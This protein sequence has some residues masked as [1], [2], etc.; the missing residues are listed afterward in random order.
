MLKLK[1][2]LS[3][4]K[5]AYGQEL[6]H[7]T[8]ISNAFKILLHDELKASNEREDYSQPIYKQY[9]SFSR[10]KNWLYI[11]KFR[12]NNVK[13]ECAIVVDANKL[14]SNYRIEPF[15][16][17]NFEKN[18]H[19]FEYEER[20]VIKKP[21]DPDEDD[22][23]AFIPNFNKYVKYVIIKKNIIGRINNIKF[24]NLLHF[25]LHYYDNKK[26][27]IDETYPI[28]IEALQQLYKDEYETDTTPYDDMIAHD[29]DEYN[30]E[31]V[32]DLKS[33]DDLLYY[34]GTVKTKPYIEYLIKIKNITREQIIKEAFNMEFP[35]ITIKFI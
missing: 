25:Y 26:S 29:F 7:Y 4:S 33:D 13:I 19:M 18:S 35:N 11:N 12:L 9:I 14:S 27:E 15:A 5:Y 30:Y 16:A 32:K 31:Y 20:L 2:I 1:K 3:E 23:V 28:A 22:D 24:A 17:N 10:S 21:F 8:S 34:Y 6:Y